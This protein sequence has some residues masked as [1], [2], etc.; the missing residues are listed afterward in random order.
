MRQPQTQESELE[1]AN[2]LAAD[3]KSTQ[4]AQERAGRESDRLFKMFGARS[5][6]GMSGPLNFS[7]M[8]K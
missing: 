1:K 6:Y 3:E 7:P 8:A 4:N 2:R 5:A